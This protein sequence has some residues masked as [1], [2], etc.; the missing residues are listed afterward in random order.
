MKASLKQGALGIVFTVSFYGIPFNCC[1]MEGSAV[2]AEESLF[3]AG[4]CASYSG[5]YK[6][7]E[8]KKEATQVFLK[9]AESFLAAMGQERSSE[10]MGELLEQGADVNVYCGDSRRTIL[11][12]AAEQGD[13]EFVFWLLENNANPAI[14]D[15][16]GETP[17]ALAWKKGFFNIVLSIV[18]KQDN[19]QEQHG[20]LIGCNTGFD[21]TLFYL[22]THRKNPDDLRIFFTRGG[23]PFI[24][25]GLPNYCIT[26]LMLACQIGNVSAVE[27]LVKYGASCLVSGVLAQLAPLS[28][29]AKFGREGII[30]FLL[31][32]FP[33]LK[34]DEGQGGVTPLRVALDAQRFNIADLMLSL[35]VAF[36]FSSQCYCADVA[37]ARYLLEKYTSAM[38]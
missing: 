3:D 29:A 18:M 10:A 9:E 15:Y 30:E 27:I 1:A 31:K 20:R 35:G 25:V 21:Y 19:V 16:S 2:V 5:Y 23:I 8:K 33:I 38:R 37:D 7:I 11:H 34:K 32:C 6:E 24:N 4:S 12:R 17:A 14:G 22:I 36:D 13:T 26:P 28:V